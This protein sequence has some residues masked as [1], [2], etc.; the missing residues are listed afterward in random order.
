MTETDLPI[1]DDLADRGLLGTTLVVLH[2]VAFRGRVHVISP[3]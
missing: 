2:G 1:L 3:T